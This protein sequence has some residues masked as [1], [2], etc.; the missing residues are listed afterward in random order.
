MLFG[1]SLTAIAFLACIV[2]AIV[3]PLTAMSNINQPAGTVWNPRLQKFTY[4]YTGE[5]CSSNVCDFD[6]TCAAFACT[7]D[8]MCFPGTTCISG[9][10]GVS[11]SAA[12]KGETGCGYDDLC[13]GDHPDLFCDNSGSSNGVTMLESTGTCKR[14][15][16]AVTATS[17]G[18]LSKTLNPPNVEVLLSNMSKNQIFTSA[19]GGGGFQSMAHPI[20]NVG[21]A[22]NIIFVGTAA[23]STISRRLFEIR[24][25]PPGNSTQGLSVGLNNWY[26]LTVTYNTDGS[27]KK[28]SGKSFTTVFELSGIDIG[29]AT[30][31]QYDVSDASVTCGSG[32][33]GPTASVTGNTSDAAMVLYR[34]SGQKAVD[35]FTTFGFKIVEDRLANN[36]GK[37][38]AV[39]PA[40]GMPNFS[41]VADAGTLVTTIAAGAPSVV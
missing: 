6:G 33:C 41:G 21:N 5:R 14:L 4:C 32:P 29:A 25:N 3:A 23:S 10:C 15:S 35:G 7:S 1:L 22:A 17:L 12:V 28:Q 24:R 31:L 13:V 39:D 8:S 18:W 19:S 34:V 11:T 2:L 30:E 16:D 27:V 38:L 36:V 26:D 37:Y 9:V 20:N 40:I